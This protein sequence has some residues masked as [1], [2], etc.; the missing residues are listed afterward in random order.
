V[1]PDKETVSFALSVF[2]VKDFGG[3][4]YGI[5]PYTY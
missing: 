4:S 2:F 1:D 3:A 5:I